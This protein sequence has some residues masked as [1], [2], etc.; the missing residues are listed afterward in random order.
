MT[1]LKVNEFVDKMKDHAVLDIRSPAEFK[2]GHLPDAISFPLFS[3]E[4]RVVVGTIYK[5]QGHEQAVLKGL[6]MVGP[7]L[8]DFV[9]QA[10]KHKGALLSLLLAWRNEEQQHG[11]VVTN[12]GKGSLYSGRRIQS[13]PVV[14]QG[15]Y[16]QRTEINYAERTYRFG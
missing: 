3:D 4:E 5:Q 15:A 2:E 14:W 16:L 10:K 13:I 1:T 9:V 11:L 8:K 12:G 7:K 6:E